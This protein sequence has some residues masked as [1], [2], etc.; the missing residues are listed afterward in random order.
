MQGI[1]EEMTFPSGV[2]TELKRA[3]PQKVS[4]I[5]DPQT[6]QLKDGT[7]VRLIGLYFPDLNP[8]ELGDFA[9]TAQDILNDMLLDQ[10]VVIHITRDRNLGRI[11]RMGHTLAHVE[12]ISDGAWIQGALLQLGLA[13]VNT[14]QRNPEMA[15]QMYKI[16]RKARAAKVG[17]WESGTY[18]VLTP[19]E[20]ND[21]LKSFQIV[22]GM[23]ESVATKNNRIYINF[24]KNWRN[25]FTV[26]IKSGDKRAFN[27][28]SANPMNWGG[29]TI[30][31]RGWLDDYNG[32]YI[33]I[34]HPAAVEMISDGGKLPGLE[35]AKRTGHI[36]K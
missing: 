3:T 36:G 24:G 29:K 23:V 7:L 4:K 14:L 8:Y 13:Q 22:E 27:K 2:Y 31:V 25:D 20:A 6:I 28:V 12:R 21:H 5:I 11:N 18:K 34:N 9:T 19:D 10:E 30:R 17:I 16:E 15:L 1:A 26:S 33:Q 35:K 32:P